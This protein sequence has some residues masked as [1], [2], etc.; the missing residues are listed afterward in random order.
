MA[1]GPGGEKTEAATPKKKSDAR[2]KGNVAKSTEVNSVVVLLSAL[3]FLRFYVPFMGEALMDVMRRYIA[4]LDHDLLYANGIVPYMALIK[5]GVTLVIKIFLPVALII[6]LFGVTVNIAQIGFLFTLEPLQPKL[7]KINPI[8][9][10]G[11]FFALKSFIEAFKNIMKL[12]IIGS[13]A[14]VTVKGEFATALRAGNET[15]G[16]I[17][18]YLLLLAYKVSMRIVLAMI[19]LAIFDFVFQRYSHEKQLKMTK[20]EIKDERKNQDG[21]PEVKG[22][23]RQLQREMAQRRMIEEVPK[24]T[25]VVTNPTHLSIA[26]RYDELTM[27]TPQI[28]AK[29]ADN[30]ALKIREIATENKIPLVEDKPL[31][32]AMYDKV[33]PGDEVPIEFFN[34][35]AEILA[36]VYRLQGKV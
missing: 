26:I 2:G 29:G 4:L 34:A 19:I 6:L 20:Q 7:S 30:I 13:V 1:E 11:K 14:Y 12:I 27:E 10:F 35:V 9:G 16:G 18:V 3:V 33:E 8:S 22:R 5:D 24:A 36:Y 28:L 31:A 15:V 17:T 21:N 32:R 23:I 25:V